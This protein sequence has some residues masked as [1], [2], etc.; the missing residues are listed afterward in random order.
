M[1]IFFDIETAPEGSDNSDDW[2]NKRITDRAKQAAAFAD[3]IK[4]AFDD[5][6]APYFLGLTSHRLAFTDYPDIPWQPFIDVS[7]VLFP[8]TY[9]RKND[10]DDNAA[11]DKKCNPTEAATPAKAP[12][13][14]LGDYARWHKPIVPVGGEIGCAM[15]GEMQTFATLVQQSGRAEAH[16]YV[17]ANYPGY[18]P[19]H[20]GVD[21]GV[22]AEIRAA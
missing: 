19:Q 1:D 7:S 18:D 4:K 12:Q 2:G 11:K 13:E 10:G 5:R 17:D 9:W 20:P 16:F 22:M 21:P 3:G 14:G 8:Q 6:H 15:K